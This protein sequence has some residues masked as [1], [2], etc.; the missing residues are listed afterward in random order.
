MALWPGSAVGDEADRRSWCMSVLGRRWPRRGTFFV[1]GSRLHGGLV[2]DAALIDV[3]RDTSLFAG[4]KETELEAVPK[5]GRVCE[6][7][8]GEYIVRA[9][10]GVLP[11]MWVVI[12][13]ETSVQVGGAVVATVGPGGYFGELALLDPTLDRNADVVALVPTRTFQLHREHLLG[14]CSSSPEIALGVMAEL[15]RRLHDTTAALREIVTS[16]PEALATAEKLGLSLA[17]R[18]HESVAVIDRVQTGSDC[19]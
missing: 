5:V 13:G 10:A 15:A 9:D 17:D 3:L 16:S 4:F 2:D 14:L 1:P 12:E 7:A 19:A 8:E 18:A 6:H 11:R